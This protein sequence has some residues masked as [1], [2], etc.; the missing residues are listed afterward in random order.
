MFIYSLFVQLSIFIYAPTL[1]LRRVSS[2]ESGYIP[3]AYVK[4]IEPKIFKK[5]VIEK[6]KVQ[7]KVKIKRKKM[8]KVKIERKDKEGLVDKRAKRT[9]SILRKTSECVFKFRLEP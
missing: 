6:V 2:K 5:P 3:A 9:S 7:E 8:K 4:E 1:F